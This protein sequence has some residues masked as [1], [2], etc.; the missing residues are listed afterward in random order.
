MSSIG[1]YHEREFWFAERRDSDVLVLENFQNDALWRNFSQ[2]DAQEKV[3]FLKILFFL[4]IYIFFFNLLLR[5]RNGNK[6]YKF[7]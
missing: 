4:I 2:P 3:K 7:L 1:S 5:L 6:N